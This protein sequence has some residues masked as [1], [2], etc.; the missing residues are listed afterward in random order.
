[1]VT[2]RGT[3][4]FDS[5]PPYDRIAP[6]AG[7]P[8]KCYLLRMKPPRTLASDYAER[9]ARVGARLPSDAVLALSGGTLHTRSNDT[10]HRFRPDSNFFYLTGL[11]EPGS[12]LLIRGGASPTSTLFVREKDRAAEVWSGR[13]PGPEGAKALTQVEEV[14][15]LS[16]LGAILRELLDGVREVHLPLQRDRGLHAQLLQASREV[17]RRDR[18]GAISPTHLVDADVIMGEDRL[19][20]DA[21][22][23]AS[24]RHAISLSALGHTE[25]AAHLRAGIYEYEVEARLEYAFRRSG[26]SGPGYGSIVGAGDNANI[27][28][29][30]E[31]A[32]MIGSDD[33][34]LVDAGCEWELFT[35]DITRCYPASGTFTAAQRALYEIVLA[36]NIA[37]IQGST[38][39]SNINA[40][41]ERCLEVL[42][43][44]MLSIGLLKGSRDS[45]L[46][47]EEYK[48][49][50]MHR[51]S[52]WLGADVHDVGSYSVDGAPRSLAAGHV[53]T[54]EPG[55][56]VA[57]DLDDVPEE[58]RGIGVRI[59]DDVWVTPEGPAVLS[60]A[61]PKT[62][63]ELEAL[64]GSA[65]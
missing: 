11:A 17:A 7:N 15:P 31:N 62:I 23:M 35:G 53:L 20:K 43:D 32:A 33:L 28:H 18:S 25:A 37:G 42:V 14:H 21:A 54:V 10:E 50:Y 48:R 13:R 46:E 29:Y 52:H 12:V 38:V 26:S 6:P 9:R 45:V 41:H 44:G 56:Y 49:F 5:T 36:A 22:A 2:R 27:L 24:L 39:G 61:A 65:L 4:T 16:A 34:L 47:R 58:F 3:R 30:V 60:D 57:N 51:T 64:V 59:E 8:D 40:I 19:V 63:A 1:M 55:I